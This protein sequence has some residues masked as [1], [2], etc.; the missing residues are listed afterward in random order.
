MGGTGGIAQGERHCVSVFA[1]VLG[2]GPGPRMVTARSLPRGNRQAPV[3]FLPQRSGCTSRAE[4]CAGLA[5]IFTRFCYYIC[6]T[7]LK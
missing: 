2:M 7:A 3:T 6:L 4:A 5:L 1:R